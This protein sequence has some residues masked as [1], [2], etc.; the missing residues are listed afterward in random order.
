MAVV[1]SADRE[2]K[3]SKFEGI[4]SRMLLDQEANSGA[5]TRGE[6]VLGP[7]AELPRHRH[8][9]EEAFFIVEGVG[10]ALVEDEEI[11]VS[12]GD[13]VLAPASVRHGFRNDS[14]A[15]LRMAFFYPAVSPS[16]EFD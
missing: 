6:L 1:R 13:A 8:L 2:L 14:T 5:V 16:A 11:D 10:Q 9:V 7:G 15:P 12:A 4:R 3:D